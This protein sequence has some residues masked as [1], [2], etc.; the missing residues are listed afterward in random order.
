MTTDL[1]KR[2]MVQDNATPN[3]YELVTQAI[4]ENL[5]SVL[6]FIEG[7][8]EEIGCPPKI[9]MQISVAAEEIFVNIASYA[10][11]PEVGDV[12]VSVE[13]S[14]NPITVTIAFMDHGKPFDP[15]KKADPNVTLSAEERDIGGL[16]I[17]M[18]KKIMDDVKYEYVDGKNIL[19][20]KKS[21]SN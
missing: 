4:D 18:T 14:D 8:L 2:E 3:N 13:V 12:T 16:G 1:D 9:Q 5:S 10:Y 11:S 21:L 15:T 7:R 17:F 19:T 6:E 20:L